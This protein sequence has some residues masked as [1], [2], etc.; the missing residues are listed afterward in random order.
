MNNHLFQVGRN[1]EMIIDYYQLF[2]LINHLIVEYLQ[3]A[4]YL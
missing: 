4:N 3:Q 1:I 2:Y